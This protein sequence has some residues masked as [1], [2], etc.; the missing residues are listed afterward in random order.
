M[1]G[2]P[3]SEDWFNPRA[4]QETVV[5]E[6]DQTRATFDAVTGALLGLRSQRTGWDIQGRAALGQSFRAYVTLPDRLYG[7]VNGLQCRLGGV[8][9]SEDRRTATFTWE[10]LHLQS[11]ERLPIR[12][13]GRASLQRGELH[14]AGQLENQ[15]AATVTT[16]SWPVLGDVSLPL[17]ETTLERQ[18]FDYG[19]FKRTPLLPCM[20]NERGYYGTNYPMQI[21]GKGAR[22]P[23]I[24]G[25]Y[26]FLPRFV[27]LSAGAQGWYAGA[28]DVSAG[29]LVCFF[30]ELRPGYLDSYHGRAPATPQVGELP[31]H[32]TF[33]AIHYPFAGPGEQGAALTEVVLAPYQG[34]WHAGVDVYRRWRATWHRPAPSPSWVHEV[35][36]WQQLQIGSAE[37]D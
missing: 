30:S 25:A 37:D 29:E 19:T 7:P 17:G 11:G 5:L 35:H 33:E 8:E 24:P 22:N 15:S 31:I 21:E 13:T 20:A 36:A 23:G 26:H 32:L 12:F 1:P 4:G 10:E 27:L 16:L 2:S 9:V 34:A 3:R 28:H 14:F 6:D 18:N